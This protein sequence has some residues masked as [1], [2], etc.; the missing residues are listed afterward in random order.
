MDVLNISKV[1]EHLRSIRV[2]GRPLF[3]DEQLDTVKA[4]IKA[5]TL[6]P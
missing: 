1:I 4:A 5:A 2:T 3:T 6:D